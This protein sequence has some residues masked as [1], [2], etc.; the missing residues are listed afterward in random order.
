M[1]LEGLEAAFADQRRLWPVWLA[2]AFGTGVA[3]YFVLPVEPGWWVGGAGVVAAVAGGLLFRRRDLALA[4][5][6][7]VALTAAGF[8]AAQLRTAQVDGRMLG[9]RIDPALYVGVIEQIELLPAGQRITLRDVDIKDLPRASTP[10]RIR[11]K[12]VVAQPELRIGQK[13]GGV[14][15]LSAPSGPAEPGAFNFRSMSL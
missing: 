12:T 11:I 10:A 6:I 3:V 15:S 1:A 8:A 9:G 14:A 7:L 2:V 13:V 4:G 5:F